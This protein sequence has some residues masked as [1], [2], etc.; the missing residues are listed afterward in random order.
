MSLIRNVTAAVGLLVL[1]PPVASAQSSPTPT[2]EVPNTLQ[3]AIMHPD[4]LA[5]YAEEIAMELG[6]PTD[7]FSAENMPLDVKDAT[8]ASLLSMPFDRFAGA[9][10]GMYSMKLKPVQTAQ[11]GSQEY[12][13]GEL[14]DTSRHPSMERGIKLTT[15]SVVADNNMS[16]GAARSFQFSENRPNGY[17]LSFVIY[18]YA[19]PGTYKFDKN[20]KSYV[21][22]IPNALGQLMSASRAIKNKATVVQHFTDAGLGGSMTVSAL[23]DG[24][25]LGRFDFV[26]LGS[27]D[28][29]ASIEG[30]KDHYFVSVF[31]G[32]F[33][34]ASLEQTPVFD[35]KPEPLIGMNNQPI[36][37]QINPA[38]LPVRVLARTDCPDT[39]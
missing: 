26:T 34:S 23:P 25:L 21:T 15:C 35:F 4:W 11:Q 16:D 32:V 38:D 14:L 31:S 18:D 1:S 10:F 12:E 24:S 39:K 5:P 2:I 22:F 3:D 6:L 29:N 36:V 8:A 33:R 27:T 20:T 30:S 37:K 7:T 9:R 17:E 28:R 19:G 13:W